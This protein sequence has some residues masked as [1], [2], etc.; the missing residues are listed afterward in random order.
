MDPRLKTSKLS[1]LMGIIIQVR[2]VRTQRTCKTSFLESSS[3]KS[4]VVERKE[5][6]PHHKMGFSS[7][8]GLLWLKC[9]TWDKLLNP[10][11][12]SFILKVKREK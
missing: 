12:F 6:I 3:E 2:P 8:L 9:M 5:H 1:A 4:S 11:E 7:N 10:S